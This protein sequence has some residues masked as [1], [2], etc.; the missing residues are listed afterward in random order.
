MRRVLALLPLLIGGRS[1]VRHVDDAG[2]A[3]YHLKYSGTWPDCRN[4]AC[5]DQ[6]T[7]TQMRQA[8]DEKL[9]C[10]GYTFAQSGVVGDGCLKDCGTGEFGAISQGEYDFFVHTQRIERANKLDRPSIML[11]EPLPLEV[12]VTNRSRT[13]GIV[14]FRVNLPYPDCADRNVTD[15]YTVSLVVVQHESS[16]PHSAPA[17]Q[18][19]VSWGSSGDGCWVLGGDYEISVPPVNWRRVPVRVVLFHDGVQISEDATRAYFVHDQARLE[20]P[21][22]SE[23][24]NVQRALHR[25]RV[26]RDFQRLWTSVVRRGAWVSW[27]PLLDAALHFGEEPPDE[28]S[29]LSSVRGSLPSDVRTTDPLH[30]QLAFSRK[31]W[32]LVGQSRVRDAVFC[33]KAATLLRS[34]HLGTDP[35]L[36]ALY[37]TTILSFFLAFHPIANFDNNRQRARLLQARKAKLHGERFTI[38]SDTTHRGALRCV[39]SHFEHLGVNVTLATSVAE[40]TG[41]GFDGCGERPYIPRGHTPQFK[42]IPTDVRLKGRPL[43][44]FFLEYRTESFARVMAAAEKTIADLSRDFSVD[45]YMSI[46][47]HWNS[48]LYARVKKPLLTMFLMSVLEQ[49]DLHILP[50]SQ[51]ADWHETLRVLQN[52]SDALSIVASAALRSEFRHLG[53]DLSKFPEMQLACPYYHI[54]SVYFP[55]GGD[56]LLLPKKMRFS[57]DLLVAELYELNHELQV[58]FR[59]HSAWLGS[60][61]GAKQ[62]LFDRIYNHPLHRS[63][64]LDPLE[65]ANGRHPFAFPNWSQ[66]DR[67]TEQSLHAEARAVLDEG[68]L[69]HLRF[70]SYTA[71][72]FLPYNSFTMLMAEVYALCI[73]MFVPSLEFAL[74]LNDKGFGMY[75]TD[76][77]QPFWERG[78]RPTTDDA[79]PSRAEWLNMSAYLT[80]PHV[81]VFD[82]FSHLLRLLRTVDLH[83]ISEKMCLHN[84]KIFFDQQELYLTFLE[85]VHANKQ[86][87]QSGSVI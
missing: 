2:A 50:P 20:A 5:F 84:H 30:L 23:L 78:F 86:A 55:T 18:S 1:D 61:A 35:K 37:D 13:K 72:V 74:E 53:L 54:S 46:Y 49:H 38:F 70:M 9:A 75:L 69:H 27:Q 87:A 12:I 79:L 17:R 29:I 56:V 59:F 22:S 77:A 81:Q 52:R 15:R 51:F 44:I 34:I 48:M 66:M 64:S 41:H 11:I 73:P 65:M 21:P 14:Y 25:H 40:G 82:S 68:Y 43:S 83:D 57:D 63:L 6:R 36:R 26:M 4:V 32:T 67:V 10:T 3:R 8:C 58:P 7:A 31:A 85:L 16:K 47:P 42:R 33:F 24:V 60:S 39:F 19:L 76:W 80:Y 62:Q 28:R 45:G 71:V